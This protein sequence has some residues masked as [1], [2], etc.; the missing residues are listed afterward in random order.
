MLFMFSCR[1]PTL[2]VAI[3]VAG[4]IVRSLFQQTRI[5]F[6]FI[7]PYVPTACFV[8]ARLPL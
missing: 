3:L 1:Y 5:A 6:T 2:S 4:T 7:E 8:L